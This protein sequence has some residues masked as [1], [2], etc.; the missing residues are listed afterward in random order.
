M[1][2]CVSIC[3]CWKGCECVCTC[4]VYGLGEYVCGGGGV[5]YMR[6]QLVHVSVQVLSS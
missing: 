2:V 4:T 1:R 3:V 5:N 6:I